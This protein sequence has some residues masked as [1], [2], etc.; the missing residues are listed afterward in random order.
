[1]TAKSHSLA[2]KLYQA[3]GGVPPGGPDGGVPPG[4]PDMPGGDDDDVID[5]DFEETT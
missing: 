4:G 1:M 2:E 5:A 3:G